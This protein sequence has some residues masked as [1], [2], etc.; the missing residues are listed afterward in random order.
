MFN[1]FKKER[2]VFDIA[3]VS[4][5]GLA[6]PDNQDHILSRPDLRVFAVADGMGGGQGGALA[7]SIFCHVLASKVKAGMSFSARV[8]AVSAAFTQANLDIRQAARDAG[9]EQMAT[10]GSVLLLDENSKTALIGYLGD[11]RIYC[12]R[13]NQLTCLTRDHTLASELRSQSG[14]V[15]RNATIDRKSAIGHVLTRA[16]GAVLKI[17]PD[18]SRLSFKPGDAFLLCSDGVTDMLRDVN[19]ALVFNLGQSAEDILKRL[20]L[21]VRNAGALDNY[22]MIVI[23]TELQ[24]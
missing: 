9:Y 19:I 16:L 18:W 8:S 11:S 15:T 6:R 17:E 22:S 7:S 3:T 24:R 5:R 12:Y 10:T 20:E 13:N 4:D 23:K 2:L 1:W 21:A 14:E